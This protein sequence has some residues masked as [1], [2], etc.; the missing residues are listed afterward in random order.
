LTSVTNLDLSNNSLVEIPAEILSLNS[1]LIELDLSNNNLTTI[2]DQFI[3]MIKLKTLRLTGNQ[4]SSEE[5]NK[6]KSRKFSQDKNVLQID[7]TPTTVT[8]TGSKTTVLSTAHLSI[9][10]DSSSPV[11]ASNNSTPKP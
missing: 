6:I 9:L 10:S 4:F 1:T 7:E 5:L 2:P 11:P 3:D 8:P